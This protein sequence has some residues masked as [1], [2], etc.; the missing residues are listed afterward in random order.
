MSIESIFLTQIKTKFS[1]LS[2]G[3]HVKSI[4]YQS[5]IK[6]GIMKLKLIFCA[7]PLTKFYLSMTERVSFKEF[8]GQICRNYKNYPY[9]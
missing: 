6:L 7:N 5:N 1:I 8:L 9:E 4:Q 3:D 2:I